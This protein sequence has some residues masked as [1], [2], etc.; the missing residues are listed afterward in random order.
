[1]KNIIIIF[2]L[3]TI[4]INSEPIYNT[5]LIS[6]DYIGI[7]NKYEI[8]DKYYLCKVKK[9]FYFIN[10]LDTIVSYPLKCGNY[11]E[12]FLHH[13]FKKYSD[14]NAN[15]L[16]IGANIGT[17][18]VILSKLFK[19][20]YSFEPQKEV[21][22][23]L[24][25][26]IQI[27]KCKNVILNNFGLGEIKK[28]MTMQCYDKDKPKNIGGISIADDNNGCEKIQINTLDSLNLSNIKFIKIDIEGYEYNA[29]LGGINLI[30][31]NKPYIIFEQHD[32]NSKIFKF[33][34]S[35]DYK[36]KRISYANDFLAHPF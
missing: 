26:N 11:W 22:D 17:H 4:I 35:L 29:L 10:P 19:N 7:P 25:L 12:S 27:N 8:V 9:Y 14:I 16:D 18:S 31:N 28:E 34:K 2:L 24:K 1:M 30:K 5:I 6:K 32:M 20:I 15:C 33:I 13:Y 23:I 21:F 3:L 36:I